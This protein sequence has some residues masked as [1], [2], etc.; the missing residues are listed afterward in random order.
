MYTNTVRMAKEGTDDV[1][2]MQQHILV[3]FK[4]LCN[5]SNGDHFSSYGNTNILTCER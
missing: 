1:S 3:L 5:H 2:I 4:G